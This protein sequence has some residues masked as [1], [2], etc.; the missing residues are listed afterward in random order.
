MGGL[1]RKQK[2]KTASSMILLSRWPAPE[3]EEVPKREN[4]YAALQGQ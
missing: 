4:V 1:G 2:A 3:D